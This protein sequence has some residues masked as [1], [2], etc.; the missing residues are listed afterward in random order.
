MQWTPA[1]ERVFLE[2]NSRAETESARGQKRTKIVCTNVAMQEAK[3]MESAPPG[4]RVRVARSVDSV[5]LCTL[6]LS[7]RWST[8]EPNGALDVSRLKQNKVIYCNIY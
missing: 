6:W 7:K 4:L 1:M 5:D 2:F 8:V 3:S